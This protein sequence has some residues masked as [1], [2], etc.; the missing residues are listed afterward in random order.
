MDYALIAYLLLAFGVA[1][2]VALDGFDP[3]IGIL[4][5]AWYVRAESAVHVF[6]GQPFSVL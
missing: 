6:R 3:G 4:L 1:M 2:Y 5:S